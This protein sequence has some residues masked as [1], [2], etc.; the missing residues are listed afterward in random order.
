MGVAVWLE[1]LGLA[2][3]DTDVGHHRVELRHQ[4]EHGVIR[5]EL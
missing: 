2:L 1:V 3:L 5:Q 4:A